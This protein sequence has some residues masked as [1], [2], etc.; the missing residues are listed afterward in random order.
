MKRHCQLILILV[1]ETEST[2]PAFS[3]ILDLKGVPCDSRK[4]HLSHG[5]DDLTRR[6]EDKILDIKTLSIKVSATN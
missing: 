2:F 6:K 3:G 4:F 5:G 1:G